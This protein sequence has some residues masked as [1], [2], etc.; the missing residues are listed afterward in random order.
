MPKDRGNAHPYKIKLTHFTARF[1]IA[2]MQHHSMPPS[3]LPHDPAATLPEHELA[4]M[5]RTAWRNSA[6]CIGRLFWKKLEVID[7]RA[8]VKPDDIFDA[9]VTHL[10]LA[11]NGGKV[12][13]AITV[14]PST[15][16]A[17]R[18]IRIWNRQ[19]VRYAG[20]REYNGTITGDPEQLEFTRKV[21]A[22]GWRPPRERSH[23]DLLPLVIDV[24]GDKS[25]V[26]PLP[27]N[28]VLEV[29]ISHPDLPWFAAL[30]LKWHAVPVV[31]DM[32]LVGGGWRFTA[33]PFSG[34]YMVTEI[35][36]RNLGDQNRYNQLPRI[37]KS[38]GL[39][40][41]SRQNLWKDRAL[42]ELNTAVLHSFHEAGVTIV[43]HHTASSQFMRHIENEEKCGR[44]V[45]GDWSWLVPPMSGSA[46]PVFHRYY[47]EV[48]PEPSFVSQPPW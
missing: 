22:M 38:M 25:R 7:A 2:I 8:A 12:R 47:D 45:P 43:D 19:L 17:G 14:F 31:S 13:S 44:T 24:P 33:A 39:D 6:R 16:E 29:S 48:V 11:T 20:Y 37:A 28:S 30:G 40:M 41:R 5:A 9:C 42:V 3:P 26:Y 18:G 4:V 1:E 32:A 36:S 46:C 34:H 15:H 35:A 10:R 23:F 21:I 27:R